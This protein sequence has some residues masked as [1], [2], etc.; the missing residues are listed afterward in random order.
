MSHL[1]HAQGED[2]PNRHLSQDRQNKLNCKGSEIRKE[3]LS[4][5]F[6]GIEPSAFLTPPSNCAKVGRRS[7]QPT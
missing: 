6:H 2:G 1:A 5:I 3:G 4:V 7:I